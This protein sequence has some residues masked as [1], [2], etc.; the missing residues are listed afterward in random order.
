VRSVINILQNDAALVAI[1]GNA[2]QIGM[3]VI[4]QTKKAPYVVVDV[5][6]RTQTNTFREA[7]TLDFI[8]VMVSSVADLTFTSGS[9]IGAFELGNAVRDALDFAT[10]GTYDSED[11]ARCIFDGGGQTHE[12]R[13]ANKKQFKREDNYLVTLAY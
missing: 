8:T 4:G 2:N 12:D 13:I 1:L 9:T 7:S 5:K 3:N 6:Q 10:P 11:L